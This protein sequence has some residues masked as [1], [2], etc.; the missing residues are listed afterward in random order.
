[1]A[2][3]C[4]TYFLQDEHSYPLGGTWRTFQPVELDM[5]TT[6]PAAPQQTVGAADLKPE[7][8]CYTGMLISLANGQQ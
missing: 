6:A 8:P 2:A 5:D 3:L 4:A 7:P 1:M